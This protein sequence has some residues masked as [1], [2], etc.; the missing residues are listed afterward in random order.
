[1]L[2]HP[3]VFKQVH[4]ISISSNSFTIIKI[5]KFLCKC[6]A[7]ASF[8]DGLAGLFNHLFFQ[9][10]LDREIKRSE[11]QGRPVTLALVDI[12]GFGRYNFKHGYIA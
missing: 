6:R 5:V 9:L 12:G 11:R 2:F 4:I 10:M 8:H 7:G 1:M 3:F